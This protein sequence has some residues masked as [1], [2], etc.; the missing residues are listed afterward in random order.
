MIALILQIVFGG[1][2]AIGCLYLAAAIVIVRGWPRRF[3]RLCPIHR[4]R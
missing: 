2:A 1:L 4:R 3:R